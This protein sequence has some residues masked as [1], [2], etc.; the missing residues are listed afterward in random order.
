M[1]FFLLHHDSRNLPRPQI[2]RLTRGE[3]WVILGGNRTALAQGPRRLRLDM[4]EAREDLGPGPRWIRA[5][6]TYRVYGPTGPYSPD[7]PLAFLFF[8]FELANLVYD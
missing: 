7:D 1:S 6:Y 5:P 3:L 2:V 4:P 8:K